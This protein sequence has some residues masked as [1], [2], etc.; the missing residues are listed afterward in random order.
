MH[1]CGEATSVDPAKYEDRVSNLDHVCK[2][3]TECDILKAD[4]NGLF[5]HDL[6]SET[7]ALSEDIRAGEKFKPFII[8]KSKKPCQ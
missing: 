7:Y 6:P 1:I 2:D 5:W 8:R 3:Y 4:E